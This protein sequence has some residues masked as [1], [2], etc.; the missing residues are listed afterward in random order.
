MTE[1]ILCLSTL[2]LFFESRAGH[3]K[4]E[5]P[6]MGVRL[7]CSWLSLREINSHPLSPLFLR[8]Y[9][10]MLECLFYVFD[11]EVAV[12]KKHLLQIL[13]KGFQESETDKVVSSLFE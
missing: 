9:R 6:T 2:D 1:T 12:K 7:T 8:S 11:P 10:K 13:E 3:C 5:S 4:Q